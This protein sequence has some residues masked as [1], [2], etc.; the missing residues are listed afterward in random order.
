MLTTNHL[1][2]AVGYAD[3]RWTY[4]MWTYKRGWP[5]AY[6]FELYDYTIRSIK[7]TAK[8]YAPKVCLDVG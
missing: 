2:H 7:R 8:L 6:D 3:I 1:L 5:A 4:E